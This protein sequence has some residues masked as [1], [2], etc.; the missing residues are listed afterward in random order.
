MESRLE[1]THRCSIFD[2][3]RLEGSSG[4]APHETPRQG[5]SAS[6]PRQSQGPAVTE[7]LFASLR[8]SNRGFI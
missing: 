1:Q 6:I 4:F 7:R 3:D 5:V 2:E 8:D